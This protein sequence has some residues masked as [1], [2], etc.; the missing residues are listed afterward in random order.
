MKFSTKD[1]Y[2]LLLMVELASATSGEYLPLKAVSDNQGISVKY[3]EQI[4]APLSKAGLVESG[5][6]SQG[7]YRLTKAP[8]D[9]TAG[10]ILRAIEGS[11]A[12]IPCLGSETNEC[13]M[14]EQCF[15]LPFWAGLDEVINQYIDSVTLEQLAQSLPAVNEGCG[16]CGTTACLALLNDAVK[17][18]GVMASN[19]V[20]GL[21]GAFIPVSEDDGMIHAAEIGCLTI[22]KLEAMTAV[23]SVGIDMVIIPGDTTPAVISAL[24]ADEAAIGMVNSKTTAVRVIPAIGRKAG[25]VLDFGG[26]LGYGPIM[27]VNQHDPSVFINRGGRLPAPMQSLKN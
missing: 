6:G 19:H 24:I 18:G 15:T 16:C 12:P 20:G 2:A 17:K 1:R 8:A 23:C 25:E 7:G 4:V 9:Y 3:L 10:E 21:S 27:A 22:E 11:V 26:L 5:R 13:P 14:S